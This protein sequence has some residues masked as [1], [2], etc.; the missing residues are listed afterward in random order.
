MD[1]TARARAV[2]LLGRFND[3]MTRV[4]DAV[5]GTQ[6]AEIEEI[7]ARMVVASAHVVTTRRIAEASGLGRRAGPRRHR[8][9]AERPRRRLSAGPRHPTP[10]R[11]TREP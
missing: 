10:S 9:G 6:W 3:D 5:F 4:V 8:R 11:R 2:E 1:A 7:L